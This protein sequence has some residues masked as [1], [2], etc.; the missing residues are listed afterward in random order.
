MCPRFEYYD[1]E[2]IEDAIETLETH[3]D[4]EVTPIAGGHSLLPTMKSGLASRRRGRSRVHRRPPRHQPRRWSHDDR[5]DDR[6]RSRR[7]R[8][9]ALGETDSSPSPPRRHQVETSGPSAETSLTPIPPLTSCS[10]SGPT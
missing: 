2:T 4:R 5:F 9:T 1:P 8:R 6:V 7:R 3:S 10:G